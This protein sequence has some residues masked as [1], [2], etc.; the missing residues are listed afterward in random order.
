[1]IK[2]LLLVVF[3]IVI[4]DV[5]PYPIIN[6]VHPRLYISQQRFNYLDSHKTQLPVS[7]FYNQFVSNY[8]G[9]WYNVP[10]FYLVGSDS[11]L[12]NYN[13]RY[14]NFSEPG[15]RDDVMYTGLFTAFIFKLNHDPL[16]LK[17]TRFVIRRFNAAVDSMSYNG[18]SGDNLETMLRYYGMLGSA[19]FDWC[20][21]DIDSSSRNQ[22]AITMFK[23]N[24]KFM[25][26]FINTSG[27]N[28]YVSSHNAW[29]CVLT[30]Q[31]IISINGSSAL[32]IQQQDTLTAWY[33]T[34]YDKWESGFFPVYGY[35]RSTSGGWNWGAAYSFWG[36]PDQ[37]TLF[38]NFLNGTNKNYYQDLPW[39]QNSINQYYYMQRPDNVCI[40][41]GDGDALIVGSNVPYR[42]AAVYSDQRSRWFSQIYSSPQMLTST[43][44]YFTILCNKDFTA[45]VVTKPD[46][47]LNW[48]SDRVGLLVSRSSWDSNAV[49]YWFFNSHSKKAAHE[50]RDNNTFSIYYK[51]PLL[52]DAGFYDSYGSSHYYNYYSRTIA[53]N[54]VTV[55]DSTEQF[56]VSG[57]LVSNDGGQI[58]SNPMMNYT[59]ITQTAYQRGRW[60]VYTADSGFV[61][62][63]T[64][65][66]LSF[67][68]QKVKRY[69]RKIVF[70][71][72]NRFVILDNII[73]TT[74]A[75][76]GSLK[77]VRWNA[78]FKNQPQLNGQMINV[79]VPGHI[80][81]FNGKNYVSVNYPAYININT[82]YPDSTSAKRIGG[83]G[84]EYWVNGTNYP[85]TGNT[86]TVYATAGKWRIE[87]IPKVTSDTV[88]MLH[89]ISVNDVGV[90][91]E[92]SAIKI[93]NVTT[94]GCDYMDNIFL[95]NIKGDTG[96]VALSA[97]GITGNRSIKLYS[98]DLKRNTF[99]SLFV[100]GVNIS[101][102][103][104][105]S[106]GIVL[107][108]LN[109]NSGN[110]NISLVLSTM[111]I[112]ENNSQIPKTFELYQNYPNPFNA[113]TIIKYDIP[114]ECYIRIVLYDIAG[115]IVSD[116]INTKLKAGSYTQIV[117]TD[118]LSSG[119]YFV[120]LESGEFKS[121]KRI[122]LLK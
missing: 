1:M 12:W 23:L 103:F 36:L 112:P 106:T 6:E 25:S 66:S 57:N 84:Y 65:A 49:Q 80:E 60:I 45:P 113:S 99:Y 78:H 105:D 90:T 114:K 70:V 109:L 38:D 82:V 37:F 76:S 8:F 107:K 47:P 117:K 98:F 10:D 74:N 116:I 71:K 35:Y 21:N 102:V 96:A 88:N 16:Q 11:T 13:I 31:N 55:Y 111:G 22:L 32:T 20:Y 19:L 40:H 2:H 34:V 69:L 119:I 72:P 5:L 54:T 61:Y 77:E 91:Q 89:T 62:S 85:V 3:L 24:R 51:K 43:Y 67:N 93:N 108:Q 100:D 27:G 110:H 30:L 53:H 68:P 14:F 75:F 18:Y 17:R 46:L 29:N 87:V 28:S 95:F 58:W 41:Q 26:S 64:D 121:T 39:I 7:T 4:Q 9:W 101:Q 73:K 97:N 42:H 52:I 44:A 81:T 50:H 79:Q 122:V 83:T 59:N 48:F 104:S 63:N 115:K 56:Y 86:D 118:N 92:Q 120:C 94:L 15:Y 33:H